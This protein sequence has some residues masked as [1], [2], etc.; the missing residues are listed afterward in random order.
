MFMV[1][2]LFVEDFKALLRVCSVETGVVMEVVKLVTMTVIKY[3]AR[4]SGI[5]VQPQHFRGKSR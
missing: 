1:Y 2:M 4:C 3:K 5:Y